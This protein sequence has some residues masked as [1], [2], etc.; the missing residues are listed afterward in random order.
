[1]PALKKN[2]GRN[3][4]SYTQTFWVASCQS[5]RNDALPTLLD[6]GSALYAD[7]PFPTHGSID[8]FDANTY[9]T[10]L[11]ILDGHVISFSNAALSFLRPW[12][13]HLQWS[14]IGVGWNQL[15]FR[16]QLPS[17]WRRR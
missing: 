13:M 16:L 9:A 5:C 1:M 8:K 6:L 3:E 14:A 10:T 2:A 15:P 7:V 12:P 17:Y 4:K 11:L